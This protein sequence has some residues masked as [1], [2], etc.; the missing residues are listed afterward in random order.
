MPGRSP[1]RRG[2]AGAPAGR[3]AYWSCR[4]PGIP[5]RPRAALTGGRVDA[6]GD[7][8]QLHAG[9]ARAAGPAASALA[10]ALIEAIA[11]GQLH[12]GDRLPS[13]RTLAASFPVARSAAVGAYEELAAAGFLVARPGGHTYVEDGAGAASRAG[14]FGTPLPPPGPRVLPQAPDI[15]YDLRPG[16]ADT[17]LIAERDWTRAMRLA[18][19]PA[20]A[21]DEAAD[22]LAGTIRGGHGE[23]RRLL[24]GYLRQARG[25]AV[26]PD[27]IFLFPSITVA[28]GAVTAVTGLAGAAVAFED[29]G[30][31]K[32]RLALAAA[33]ARI[34]PVPVDDDGI[35]ARD[36]QDDDR[37]V[38]VT[39]AHQFPLGGRMPV[40]RRAGL[41]DWAAARDALVLED[42]YDGEF[43]Y[44]V[45]P[46][47]PL[48]AMPAAAGQ[49]VYLGTSAKVLSHV[50]RISWAVLPGRFRH[51]MWRYLNASGDAV[52]QVS[53]ALLGS[54]IETGA[55][56]RHQARAMRTYSARQARFVAA[57]R[58]L[59]PGVRALGI[60][61]GLHVVLTFA[62]PVDDVALAAR[63]AAAGL[64]CRPLSEHYATPSAA[65]R[66]GLVCGYSRLPETKAR[67]AARLIAQAAAEAAPAR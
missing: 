55:L 21:P 19:A 52:S 42:D 35:C 26:D 57:C 46:L 67:P 23:L 16:L 40:P 62:A 59:V 38:Y 50:L 3:R 47:T 6:D 65:G 10:R 29:P 44:G 15:V 17:G 56:T 48:R 63:L 9:P 58:D 33:G 51:G 4:R 49:V 34:R 7:A 25:L 36:L 14:A 5:P 2:R 39:P 24:A 53:A 43:R 54:Y 30:Y 13:T 28:L 61:A 60:E 1:E 31:A 11:S 27:D 45:P 32:G 12:D 20:R 66:T 41:L 22:D 64:A 37:A 8:S 18:A